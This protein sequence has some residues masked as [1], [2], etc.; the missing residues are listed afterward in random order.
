MTDK[1]KLLAE[2]LKLK[3]Y[4]LGISNKHQLTVY[5]EDMLER[6]ND[7]ITAV[8]ECRDND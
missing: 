2:V 1:Q 5:T 7:I 6:V 4:L 3:M 8:E